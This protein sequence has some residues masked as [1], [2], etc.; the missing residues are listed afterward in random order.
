LLDIVQGMWSRRGLLLLLAAFP[1]CAQEDLV[2]KYCLGCHN[3]K[4]K[5][6]NLSLEQLTLEAHPGEWE[7]VL[8]RLKARQMPLATLPSTLLERHLAAAR[9]IFAA[10]GVPP[11]EFANTN[12]PVY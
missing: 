12:K 1:A 9:K 3:A 10:A 8:R 4:L 6:A 5:T 2:R 7:K 11:E